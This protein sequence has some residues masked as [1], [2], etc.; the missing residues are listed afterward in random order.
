[1]IWEFMK[2]RDIR[3]SGGRSA[4]VHLK[5]RPRAEQ[6]WVAAKSRL[7]SFQQQ[8]FQNLISRTMGGVLL[9]AIS[10]AAIAA[11]EKSMARQGDWLTPAVAAPGV[12][13]K[14]IS[15]PSVHGEVSFM[16]ICPPTMR[17]TK[18]G[19]IQHFIGYTEPAAANA[20]SLSSPACSMQQSGKEKFRQ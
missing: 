19:A 17:Q 11:D 6:A 14:T 18:V 8:A 1:M 16:S 15:S 7:F 3:N 5:S 12:T 20:A 2:L 13:Y 9:L 4:A 10:T